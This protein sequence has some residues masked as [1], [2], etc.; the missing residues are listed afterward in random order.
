MHF[1]RLLQTS[2]TFSQFKMLEVVFALQRD[3]TEVIDIAQSLL[4][5]VIRSIQGLEKYQ[6]LTLTAQ[7]LYPSAG[8]FKLGLTE[9]GKLLRVRFSEAK[10]ILKNELGLITQDHDDLT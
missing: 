9:N 7:R 4:V 5:S 8:N 3:W 6:R 1:S 2:L 10:A